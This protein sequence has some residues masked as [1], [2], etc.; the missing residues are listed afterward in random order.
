M[1]E[2]KKY[3]LFGFSS[4]AAAAFFI[5]LVALSFAYYANIFKADKGSD[6]K[7]NIEAAADKVI[8]APDTKTPAVK[9]DIKIAEN[10]WVRGGKDAKIT[11]VEFSDFQCPYCARFHSVLKE[12]LDK[13]PNDVRAVFKHLPLAMHSSAE[14]AALAAEC[15]G[16]QGKFW[17]YSDA[18]FANQAK[19]N[20][21]YLG[22]L[23]KELKLDSAKFD[24]CLADKKYLS[25]VE[26]DKKQASDN[27]ARSTPTWFINGEKV[28]GSVAIEKIEAMISGLLQ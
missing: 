28:V 20:A 18:L 10:D 21:A 17:E 3:F 25:K 16:E 8:P 24:K 15:A 22:A 9:A 1:T 7:D 13:H 2:K 19:I 5:A 4:G 14:P 23:A 12:A 11:I 6:K 27:G 26:A